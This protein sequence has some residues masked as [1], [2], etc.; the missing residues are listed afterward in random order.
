MGQ[1]HVCSVYVD[2]LITNTSTQWAHSQASPVFCSS[3]RVQDKIKTG[4]AWKHIILRTG[5]RYRVGQRFHSRFVSE[6]VRGEAIGLGTLVS[7]TYIVARTR[8]CT[9]HV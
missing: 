5:S 9:Q 6:T 8:L 4:E 7:P 1:I 2:A 3:V